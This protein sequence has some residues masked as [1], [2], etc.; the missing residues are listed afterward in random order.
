MT[1]DNDPDITD[2]SGDLPESYTRNTSVTVT[3]H[4]HKVVRVHAVLEDPDHLMTVDFELGVADR[5]IREARM[6]MERAPFPDCRKALVRS[7]DLE[8][9]RIERGFARTAAKL[10][11]GKHGCAHLMETLMSAAR[12]AS[13]AVTAVGAGSISWDT[14]Y[15]EDPDFREGMAEFLKDSCVVFTDPDEEA[16][17][18]RVTDKTSEPIRRG[19][20]G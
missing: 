19:D 4:D 18:I 6:E 12:L 17:Q 20:E 8:G 14:L 10:V 5:I 1:D 3:H 13:S 2:A 11:A 9:L 15:H 7:K 16:E